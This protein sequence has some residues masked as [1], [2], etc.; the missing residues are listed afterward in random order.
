M[1]WKLTALRNMQADMYTV[2]AY[3]QEH[4]HADSLRSHTC[5]TVRFCFFIN[6]R[7]KLKKIDFCFAPSFIIICN[8]DFAMR[9]MEDKNWSFQILAL[10]AQS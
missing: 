9:S 1:I 10:Q 4:K 7:F 2:H 3:L 5:G 6:A 8:H